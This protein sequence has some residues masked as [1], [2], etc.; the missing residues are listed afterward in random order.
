LRLIE[1]RVSRPEPLLLRRL[2]LSRNDRL[3]DWIETCFAKLELQSLF[4]A[5]PGVDAVHGRGASVLVSLSP[6]DGLLVQ[7][8]VLLLEGLNVL[9]VVVTGRS[10][11]GQVGRI[12]HACYNAM[13][14]RV[15]WTAK[16]YPRLSG[17]LDVFRVI[18]GP[19]LAD[20]SSAGWLCP[21]RS[22]P[23]TCKLASS[24]Q[25]HE[26]ELQCGVLGIS[27]P[28]SWQN[29]HNGRTFAPSQQRRRQGFWKG[30]RNVVSEEQEDLQEGSKNR[31][32]G[33]LCLAAPDC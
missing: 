21:E 14:D 1:E 5:I 17:L 19:A 20:S 2:S 22:I 4:M 9:V 24:C 25:N 27:S 15:H 16:G 3:D 6:C 31:T 26:L 10:D 8:L 33:I 18:P 23:S 13:S 29:K 28:A 12:G 32:R 30:V 11:R 7:S